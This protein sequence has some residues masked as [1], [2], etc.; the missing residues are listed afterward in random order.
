MND[1][2]KQALIE[3]LK[4]GKIKKA[5][6]RKEMAEGLINKSVEKKTTSLS[7]NN[8]EEI[9]SLRDEIKE[10]KALMKEQN[11]LSEKQEIRELIKEN[12]SLKKDLSQKP[13]QEKPK[14]EIN[15]NG[16]KDTVP[17][18]EPVKQ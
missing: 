15:L 2:D 3:R 18:K 10:L 11:E 6:K 4:A 9:K 17:I 5:Q 16:G 7:N 13:K 8:K 14:P 1:S 12:E